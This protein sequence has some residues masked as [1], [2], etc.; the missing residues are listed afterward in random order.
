MSNRPPFYQSQNAI[1]PVRSASLLPALAA[2]AQSPAQAESPWTKHGPLKISKN[3]RMIVH[4]DGTPFF[5]LGD[6]AWELFHR[7]N[8]EEAEFYLRNRAE[9]GFTVIQAV[10]LAELGGL[11]DPNPYGHF[12][13]I[14]ND[15]ARPDI[16]EGGDYWDHVDFVI[17]KAEELGL[18]I[19]LLPAWGDKWNKKWGIGPEVFNPVN[20]EAYGKWLGN[21]YKD[22]PVIWI[23]GG[24]RPVENDTHR[25]IMAAM[26]RGLRFGDGGTHLM[27]WHPPGGEGSSAFFHGEDWLDFNMRQNGHGIEYN[28]RYDQTRADYDREPVKPVIDGEPVY[29]DHPI[30]FKASE[31]GHSTAADIRRAFYWDLFG[32]ACGHTYGHHSVWQMY[33]PERNHTPVNNPLLSWR[34]ALD[35]PGAAQMQHGR[36]LMESR[37]MANRVPDDSIIVKSSVETS[38]PGAGTRRFVGTR[39][40]DGS[41]A[42]VYVATGRP[43]NI[44]MSVIKG[45]KVRAWW[46]DPRTGDAAAAGEFDNVGEQEFLPPSRG[47]L[48]DWILVLDDVTKNYP[49]P[50][51]H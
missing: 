20:A 19:G 17:N 25:E 49:P 23:L 38:M 29:E 44:S 40:I 37:P 43:F 27:T 21:R 46:F 4:A 50:G 9:K 32:G 36:R 45:P 12:P 5:Y 51:S 48:L 1:R 34:E 28:G 30:A 7:L 11:V 22:K 2:E 39:D 24:D 8:R 33:D 31:L 10:A 13:L 14:D 41:Y 47:E 18:V 3:H 42:M 15:P 26:A 6:T 35:Q 16:K